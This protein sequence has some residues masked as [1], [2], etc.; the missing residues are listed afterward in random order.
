MPQAQ[1]VFAGC[2]F[3]ILPYHLNQFYNTFFFA[4]FVGTSLLPFT[5]VFVSRVCRQDSA[6]DIVGLAIS[7]A[8][9]ILTHLP[10]T[11]IGSICFTVY[12][13]TL[14]R[15]NG[16]F[17]QITKLAIGVLLGLTASSF[18]WIKVL[19]EKDLLAKTLVYPDPWQ[20]YKLHFLLTPIQAFEN[21]M[22]SEVYLNAT[23]FYD[24]IFLYTVLLV[25][26]T[27]VPFLILKR[28]KVA[29]SKGVWL[30]F[31]LCCFLAVPFSRTVWEEVTLLQEV[32]F[33]W[34]WLAVVSA[35][36]SV[37]AGM[38]IGIIASWFRTSNRP[39]ALVISGFVLALVAFSVSQI[40]R[41]SPFIPK[42]DTAARMEQIEGDKGL[43]FWWTIWTRKEIFE[44]KE[45]ALAE[46]RVVNIEQ[47]TA[48]EKEFQI[49]EGG[50]GYAR[51]ALFYH[52]DWKATVNNAPAETKPD[53]N[54]ALLVSIPPEPAEVKIS[55]RE[56]IQIQIGRW[57][58]VAAWILFLGLWLASK[59]NPRL[60]IN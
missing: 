27:A 8:A 29:K 14:L 53:E 10:L 1:A 37:L 45:K 2:I 19:L 5:F 55:F 24:L 59:W 3:A 31:L 22:A 52:P 26:A 41:P 20:D 54:G 23:Y 9:L 7:F 57:A 51:V 32:Q 48:T 60:P 58:S 36:A 34:R 28:E 11:V 18:F 56:P 15:R 42:G 6:K 47:W 21:H 33:P 39:F 44:N 43:T 16:Y 50:S 17:S 35:S 40:I 4:E 30:V 38:H 25:A 13:L 12:G 46:N 49:S